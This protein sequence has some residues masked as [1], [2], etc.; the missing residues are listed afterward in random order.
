MAEAVQAYIAL[1]SNL[2]HPRSQLQRAVA[3][4]RDIP[5]TQLLA[6]SPV[7]QNPAVG[8]GIQPD[9]LNAVASLQTRLPAEQL[10]HELQAIENRQGRRRD[11]RW[12]A[13]TIDLDLLLYGDTHIDT[14]LLQVPH[15]RMLERNFVLYPLF[16][17]APDLTLPD[18]SLLR[19]HLDSCPATG[20]SRQSPLQSPLIED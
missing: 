17:M 12:G 14:P 16:D 10:L 2:D 19:T 11:T 8:P 5:H 6:T 1:G 20:L 18:G 3:A 9:Y 15:P 4:L 7:Y 13:R